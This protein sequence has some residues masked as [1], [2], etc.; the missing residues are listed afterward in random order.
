MSEREEA[1]RREAFQ[2]QLDA[3]RAM[4]RTIRR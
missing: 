2:R 1:F 4:N 3:A